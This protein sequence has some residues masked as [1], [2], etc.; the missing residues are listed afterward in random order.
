[1]YKLAIF[2]MDGTVF[3]SHLDWMKIRKELNIENNILN[4]IYKN[5][6]V[7][8][9]KLKRLEYFEE[10]NTLKT[11]PIEGI[12]DFL[13]YLKINNIST[14]LVTNNNK[15]NCEFLL[16]KF[17]LT[18]DTVLTRE[19]KL[20]KP[21]PE[22]FF[23][24]MNRFR[25]GSAETFY[26]GDSHYDVLASNQSGIANIFIIKNEKPINLSD[27]DNIVYFSNYVELK[28]ILKIK[29]V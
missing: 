27:T 12:S 23:Y 24:I 9:E 14:A 5:N 29:L 21:S 1:M 13:S 20:W 2:D 15:K 8:H 22:P 17:S 7:D 11:T 28:D 19:M 10:E 18:F 3:E 4:E 25:C 6:R 16:N 26:I